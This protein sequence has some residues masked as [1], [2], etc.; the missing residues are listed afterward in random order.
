M[1]N[2]KEQD[3]KEGHKKKRAKV[4]IK[5]KLMGILLPIVVLVL[6]VI[7]ILVYTNISNMMLKNNEELIQTNTESIINDIRTWMNGTITALEMERDAIQYF[8]LNEEEELNYIKHTANQYDAFPAG[9]YLAT[10]EGE[11]IHASFVPGPEFNVFEKPWYQDGLKSEQFMFGEVYFDEDSQSYVVGASGVLKNKN[12]SIRGVAAADIYL[13]AISEIVGQVQMEETGGMVLVDTLTGTIIGHKDSTYLGTSLEEHEELMYV[14][15]K[16]EIDKGTEGIITFKEENGEQTYLNVQKIPESSWVSVSYVPYN[17]ILD[18]LY[19]FTK[20]LVFLA[21]GGILIL[22]ILMERFIHM[23][24]RPVK[25]LS[26]AVGAI[27]EGDFSVQVNV[28]TKDEIGMMAEGIKNF[29]QTMRGIIIEI[30]DIS[31]QL[32]EQ[33]IDGT[34][35]SQQLFESA[36]MQSTSMGD[37]S[38]TVK[39]LAI[40][41][42]EVAESASRLANLVADVTQSGESAESQMKN[43]VSSSADGQNDMLKVSGYMENVSVK[44]NT[45]QK[46]AEQMDQSVSKINSIVELIGDIAE[47]TNLLSLNASIEAARAGEAGR[48]FAV[49]A[50]HIGKL[51]TTSKEAV[52]DIANLTDEIKSLVLKTVEE[53]Q[54]SGD[55]IKNS[56]QAVGQAEVTFKQIYESVNYTN[57]SVTAMIGMIRE[58]NDIALNVAGITQEQSAS[59]EEILATTETMKANAQGVNEDSMKMSDD[60]KQLEK[61][62]EKLSEC[63]GQFKV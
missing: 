3:Y 37:M 29:I 5:L 6:T 30:T 1:K 42:S 25:K 11:L 45:L 15:M 36:T 56:Q 28:N 2:A 24:V 49:V 7:I 43:A 60:A 39:E 27:T 53:T 26:N 44:M 14:F 9:I 51:A 57:Q 47:E 54:E 17:E 23:I 58:V 48:G 62:S 33:S 35:I 20:N 13:N 22:I 46:S 10:T 52:S 61:N 19:S 21:I 34:Q 41:I 38:G 32:D 12:G 16:E 55:A 40:S 31:K 59:S 63:M 8:N 50:D 18:E 4:G